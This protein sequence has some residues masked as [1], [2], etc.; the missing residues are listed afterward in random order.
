MLA[1][2]EIVSEPLVG[3]FN[4]LVPSCSLLFGRVC[5]LPSNYFNISSSREMFLWKGEKVKD[6][7]Y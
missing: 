5:T 3:L 4:L 2:K 1:Q 6:E 7:A